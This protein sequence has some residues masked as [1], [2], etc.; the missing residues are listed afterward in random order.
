MGNPHAVVL[1]DDVERAPVLTQGPQIQHHRAFV[2]GVN[3]GFMQIVDPAQVRLRVFE[4]GAGETL[5]CGSG[6]CA[7]VVAGIRLGLL[8]HRVAV[9]MRGGTLT[10]DWTGPGEDVLLS[11]PATTVFHGEIDLTDDL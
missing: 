11:G 2:R 6:A 4:R 7:A 9:Q 3:V 8:A 5:A 1:V 10:I